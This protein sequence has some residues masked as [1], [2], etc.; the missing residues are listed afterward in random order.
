MMSDQPVPTAPEKL[1]RREAARKAS[2]QI[3][4]LDSTLRQRL[5]SIREQLA[6][7][8]AEDLEAE[9]GPEQS[10]KPRE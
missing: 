10:G 2:K 6:R 7:V 5:A 3:D 4:R 9:I 8:R 1:T